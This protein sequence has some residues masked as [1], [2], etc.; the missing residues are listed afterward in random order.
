[1]NHADKTYA[2]GNILDKNG[3]V[4]KEQLD[5]EFEQEWKYYLIPICV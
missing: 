5:A 1:M 3:N 4:N 2:Y